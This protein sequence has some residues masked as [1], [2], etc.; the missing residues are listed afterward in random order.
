MPATS[1]EV[2]LGHATNEMQ[3]W[4]DNDKYRHNGSNKWATAPIIDQYG[5]Q[6]GYIILHLNSLIGGYQIGDIGYIANNNETKYHTHAQIII[7]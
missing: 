2:V 7:E 5:Q 3:I 1:S 6:V 4:L